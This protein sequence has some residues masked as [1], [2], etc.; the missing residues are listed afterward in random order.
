MGTEPRKTP[1][2][3]PTILH[4]TEVCLTRWWIGWHTAT[5]TH[6]YSIICK[7]TSYWTL[8][9]CV[10]VGS[11]CEYLAIGE[12]CFIMPHG[13]LA[14]ADHFILILRSDL[15][16][17][18][19]AHCTATGQ[20]CCKLVTYRVQGMTFRP[21]VYNQEANS[22]VDYNKILLLVSNLT[23]QCFLRRYVPITAELV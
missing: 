14:L 21:A 18:Y 8:Y 17:I 10:P 11:W 15:Y 23:E 16:W 9:L 20:I 5:V 22:T 12:R 13:Y 3:S 6:C 7:A 19:A 4:T 1:Q 2:Q